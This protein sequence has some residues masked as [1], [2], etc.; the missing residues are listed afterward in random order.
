MTDLRKPAQQLLSTPSNSGRSVYSVL[1]QSGDT[2]LLALSESI[3]VPVGSVVVFENNSRGLIARYQNSFA[4]VKTLSL[5]PV[6]TAV[7]QPGLDLR[8]KGSI[9]LSKSFGEGGV[10]VLCQVPAQHKAGYLGWS[11]QTESGVVLLQGNDFRS[12]GSCSMPS[13][14]SWRPGRY[15]LTARLFN[16]SGLVAQ[17]QLTTSFTA[18]SPV[19]VFTKGNYDESSPILVFV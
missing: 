16:P 14:G 12:R 11:L 6:Q 2:V 5:T 17:K 19:Q 8:I 3:G 10:S 9:R 7:V 18:T 4:L 13:E 15:I 1:E